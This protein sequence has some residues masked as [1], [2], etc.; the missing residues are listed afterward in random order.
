MER[1]SFKDMLRKTIFLQLALQLP[2]IVTTCIA[3][4]AAEKHCK[5]QDGCCT[6]IPRV[7]PA[8]ERSSTFL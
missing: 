7:S 6:C 8:T 2:C 4:M 1:T 3:T 5:L